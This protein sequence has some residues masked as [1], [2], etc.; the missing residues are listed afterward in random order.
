MQEKLKG[1]KVLVTGGA[2]FI[3]SH[4][5]DRLVEIGAEVCVL[6]NLLTGK[7]ENIAQHS[8]KIKFIQKDF[9]DEIAMDEALEGVEYI[10]H[11]AALRSVPQSVNR[12]FDYHEVN[13][14]GTLKLFLKASQRQVKRIAFASS[15]SIY[16]ER[17]DFPEKETD[18]P[19]P[20]SPYAASNYMVE[21]YA[22]I[23]SQLYN[24]EVV[25][26]RYFNV[27]GPRQSLENEYAVVIPKFIVCLI[28]GESPPVYGDGSQERDFTYIDNVVNANIAALTADNVAGEAFN[29]A[30]GKPYSVNYLLESLQK[31]MSSNIAPAYLDKRLGDVLKTCAAVD[32]AK[33]MLG[34]QAKV[35]FNEGLKRTVKWFKENYK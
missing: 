23:F 28:K 20:L 35:D 8:G 25:S 22:Y 4:I 12:P 6:D 30:D 21:Q 34:W 17:F 24:L 29:I 11:Q 32:K 18:L 15:S 13:V 5:V 7:E 33:N 27:F 10:A 19:V 1:K 16:G 31:I 3:G 26:L 9:R 2:G 14:T